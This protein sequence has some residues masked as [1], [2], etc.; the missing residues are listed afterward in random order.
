MCRA[1]ADL[2]ID[3]LWYLSECLLEPH[4]D[5]D[6]DIFRGLACHFSESSRNIL[7]CDV[8]GGDAEVEAILVSGSLAGPV[9]AGGAVF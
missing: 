9:D 1:I 3:S 2:G 6:I 5:Q 4:I 8:G 7:A